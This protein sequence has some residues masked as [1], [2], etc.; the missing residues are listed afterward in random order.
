[1]MALRPAP[2][3]PDPSNMPQ[4]RKLGETH[5]VGAGLEIEQRLIALVGVGAEEV[6]PGTY[7]QA[8]GDRAA[9]SADS[10]RRVAVAIGPQYG[11]V[12]P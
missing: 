6:E 4:P 8:I 10:G 3:A 5:P 11:T 7:I 2:T 12:S 9:G 1:M